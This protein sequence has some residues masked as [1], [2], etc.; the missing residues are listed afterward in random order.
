M[1][2]VAFENRS[3]DD[4]GAGF[5]PGM[6]YL[7]GLGTQCS[8]FPQWTETDEHDKSLAQYVGQ[9]TGAR[10]P[11]TVADCKPS[12][13]CSTTADNLFRQLR[14]DHRDAV[15]FV[16]GA[17]RPCS[18]D[19]NAAKHIPALYLW[20]ADDRAHC[21]EQV[22]PL[23][24]L[25][26]NRLPAFAFVTPTLCNDG[27]DCS[28]QVVDDWARAHLQ[29]VLD[30]AAYRRGEVAVFVWYDEI[31]AGAEP[32]DHAHRRRRR[33]AGCRR[34][35]GG[36]PARVAVDAR[37]ALPRRRV[38]RPRT[39]APPRTPDRPAPGPRCDPD[40]GAAAPIPGVER[41][42]TSHRSTSSLEARSMRVTV[43]SDKCQGHNRCYALAPDVFDVDDLG[44]AF[45][46]IEGDAAARAGGRRPRRRRQLPRVRDHDRRSEPMSTPPARHRLGH[47]L[48]PH[49]PGLGQRPVPDLGRAPREVPGRAPDRYGGVWLPVTPRG[50][51]RGRVRHR[52]LHV[53][54]RGRERDPTRR[55][56]TCPRRSAS[57]R[58]SPRTRRS[59]S[60]PA[61]SCSPR[62][63]RSRIAALEPF[64]RELCRELLDA[65]AGQTEF[66]A[67]VDYAQHIPVRVI[68]RC[69]ASR[70]RTPTSSAGSSS[71]SSRTSTC[72]RRGA[73][74]APGAGRDR[75]VPRGADRRA[76]RSTRA[77]T[78][79]RSCSRPRSTARSSS[80]TTCAARW[81]C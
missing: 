70:T 80:P 10:Q 32:L 25:D 19:G 50:R 43:D 53:A 36:D 42:T 9:V 2:V 29:P 49:R 15:N 76:P 5:G 39:C 28:D 61:G 6:P 69:S 31:G 54:Q 71:R 68:V 79:P 46:K 1:I 17:T 64:T 41:V 33:P 20:G 40:H 66:D 35:L 16:E 4:V 77:T 34:D 81:C 22:R 23:T 56:T 13:T 60:T 72:T 27:H 55:R 44:F 75:R 78:S 74:G 73:R 51:R 37:R 52:A 14:T 18:A 63:R 57:R 26:P 65:T 47:R 30:S 8:W 3:W 7:H 45:V 24:D 38:R 12:A 67:A 62:S 59:T 21:P 11:G 58:R 48:R